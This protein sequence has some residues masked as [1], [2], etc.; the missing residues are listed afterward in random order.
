[1]KKNNELKELLNH[2]GTKNKIKGRLFLKRRAQIKKAYHM[3]ERVF[4]QKLYKFVN[5]CYSKRI[6]NEN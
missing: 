4:E 3:N 1:M 5:F 6:K 2:L